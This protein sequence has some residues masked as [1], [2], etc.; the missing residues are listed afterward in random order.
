MKKC[1]KT[2]CDKFASGVD[3]DTTSFELG[4]SVLRQEIE[5]FIKEQT[6]GDRGDAFSMGQD[7]GLQWIL[8]HMEFILTEHED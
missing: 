5:S 3:V 4:I 6:K 8:D 7:D 2:L 1:I